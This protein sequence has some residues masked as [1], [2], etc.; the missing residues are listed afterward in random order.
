MR[1]DLV[2]KALWVVQM[3]LG[4][5]FVFAG[6]VKLMM[7]L[8]SLVKEV[9]MPGWFILFISVAEL[10]GGIGLVLPALLRIKPGL[11]PLAAAGLL[12][13]GHVVSALAVVVAGTGHRRAAVNLLWEWIGVGVAVVVLR[14]AW[15]DGRSCVSIPALMVVV[16]VVL[17]GLGVWQHHYWYPATRAELVQLESLAGAGAVVEVHRARMRPLVALP[18]AVAVAAE[19]AP[20]LA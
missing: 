19:E 11:T 3:L 2:H 14:R 18:R 16:C 4:A 1:E 10:L 7:P 17:S 9:G 15:G 5:L 6:V 8:E 13:A 12:A 20:L